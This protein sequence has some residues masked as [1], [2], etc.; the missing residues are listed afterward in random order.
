MS[1]RR[2]RAD[3][4]YRSLLER[5]D[6]GDAVFD[7]GPILETVRHIEQ[8]ADPGYECAVI[9]AGLADEAANLL[10]DFIPRDTIEGRLHDLIVQNAVAPAADQPEGAA[11]HER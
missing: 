4:I 8:Q 5:L 10:L 3:L 6:K 1:D 9:I 11:P 7:D 2:T